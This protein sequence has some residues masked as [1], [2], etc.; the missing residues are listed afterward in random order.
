L[1][2]LTGVVDEAGTDA[3]LVAGHGQRIEC[4]RWIVLIPHGLADDPPRTKIQQHRWRLMVFPFEVSVKPRLAHPE[5]FALVR[6]SAS[7]NLA[8]ASGLR[9]SSRQTLSAVIGNRAVNNGSTIDA[10][11]CVED[12]KEI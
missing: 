8:R 6:D 5:P 9:F 11:P 1:R 3:P 12:E 10:F 7:T 2:T 4:Q